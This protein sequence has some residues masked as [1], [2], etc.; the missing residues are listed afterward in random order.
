MNLRGNALTFGDGQPDLGHTDTG[1]ACLAG[2]NNYADSN[3]DGE[4]FAT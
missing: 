1:I 4:P 2:P 3:G